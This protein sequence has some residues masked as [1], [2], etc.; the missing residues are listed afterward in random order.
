MKL[1]AR[2]WMG[3]GAGAGSRVHTRVSVGTVTHRKKSMPAG[4]VAPGMASALLRGPESLVE[5]PE[6][7]VQILEAD[8]EA[9]HVGRHPGRLLLFGA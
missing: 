8:R 3:R 2:C 9:D 4:R 6:N 7:V 5:I 1:R